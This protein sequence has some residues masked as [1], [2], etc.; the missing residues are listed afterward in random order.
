MSNMK[1]IRIIMQQ[2]KE[3]LEDLV[4]NFDNVEVF[5]D[6]AYYILDDI[7]DLREILEK[8]MPELIEDIN[9]FENIIN[10]MTFEENIKKL[11]SLAENGLQIVKEIEKHFMD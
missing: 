2:I 8:K 7:S 11:K 10:N 1:E 4:A 6:T 9:K 5:Q 3:D